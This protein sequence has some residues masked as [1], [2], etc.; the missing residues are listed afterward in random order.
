MARTI[1]VIPARRLVHK[2]TGQKLSKFSAIPFGS[3]EDWE[4][5]TC[6]WTWGV[7]DAAGGYTEG[8]GRM[9]E[10][11]KAGAIAIAERFCE[12]TG[13]SLVEARQ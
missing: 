6:G 4:L 7:T 8:L 3:V 9:A 10:Q 1:E 12:V 5:Q 13:A 2:E 11:T